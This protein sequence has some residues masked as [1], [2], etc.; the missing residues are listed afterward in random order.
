MAYENLKRRVTRL[1]PANESLTALLP[2]WLQDDDY[3]APVASP[4]EKIIVPSGFLAIQKDGTIK[5]Q[6]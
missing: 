1:Y 4:D 6:D 3:I 2:D 5:W